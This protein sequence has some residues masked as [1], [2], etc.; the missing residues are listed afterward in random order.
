MASVF[1]PLYSTTLRDAILIITAPKVGPRRR[2][3]PAGRSGI[4]GQRDI[5]NLRY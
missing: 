1:G 4:S 2:D 3:A 5:V